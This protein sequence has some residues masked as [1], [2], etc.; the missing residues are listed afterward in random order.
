VD[1]EGPPTP[2]PSSHSHAQTSARPR[3][4]LLPLV[5]IGGAVLAAY[6]TSKTPHEQHLTL[7]LG[8]RA[9][10]VIGVEMQYVA[11]D[12]DVARV[13]RFTFEPGKAPRVIAHEPH[14]TDGD[15]RLH[16]D[17][18]TREGRRTVERRVTL[19]GGTTQVDVASEPRTS[20]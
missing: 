8:D 1:D 20:P 15:Y 2:P 4:R 7:V 17:L 11:P 6:L 18:D 14:L 5:L 10:S 13:A 16:I 9:P 3:R 12:G 19:G